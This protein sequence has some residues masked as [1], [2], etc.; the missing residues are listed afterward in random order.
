[1]QVKNT[2]QSKETQKQQISLCGL[3]TKKLL[4]KT[5]SSPKDVLKKTA[6]PR[7]ILFRKASGVWAQETPFEETQNGYFLRVLL[8]TKPIQTPPEPKSLLEA[9]ECMKPTVFFCYIL[10]PQFFLFFGLPKDKVASDL[11]FLWW[12]TQMSYTPCLSTS[13][14]VPVLSLLGFYVFKSLLKTS[15]GGS[16]YYFCSPLS[17]WKR[18]VLPKPRELNN[19]LLWTQKCLCLNSRASG[20]RPPVGGLTHLTKQV[21]QWNKLKISNTS[22]HNDKK[23]S[24]T[25]R[26]T[27]HRPPIVF[28]PLINQN[29]QKSSNTIKQ[30]TKKKQKNTKQKHILKKRSKLNSL[31]PVFRSLHHR[32]SGS[33]NLISAWGELV[34]SKRR[35]GRKHG[36]ATC[37]AL[38][39]NQQK[40]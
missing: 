6:V 21:P 18:G 7:P 11:V 31:S 16:R 13:I 10:D 5:K 29:P 1:M 2:N 27:T 40:L 22:Q 28:F 33:S 38:R 25:N 14:Q 23:T 9:S 36:A 15:V 4:L 30:I 17:F 8:G 37:W 39:A 34:V 19:Q 20:S 12:Y 35:S 32:S 24:K 3:S 26:P